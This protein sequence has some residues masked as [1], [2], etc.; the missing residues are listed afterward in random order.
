MLKVFLLFLLFIYVFSCFSEHSALFWLPPPG[1]PLFLT[2]LG[3]QVN[4]TVQVLNLYYNN[5]GDKGTIALA[6]AL[7]VSFVFFRECSAFPWLPPPGNPSSLVVL[8]V[9]INN[10]VTDL[11]LR[12]NEFGDAGAIAI[13]EALKVS[14]VFFRERSPFSWLPPPR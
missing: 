10:T 12:C 1:N 14:F 4:K 5:V 8:F 6:E 7:K 3:A 2:R 13:S 11:D 9:Q